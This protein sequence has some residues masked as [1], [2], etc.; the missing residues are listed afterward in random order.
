VV[1]L[2]ISELTG[3]VKEDLL[4]LPWRP[5]EAFGATVGV[6]SSGPRIVINADWWNFGAVPL[7]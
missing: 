4:A 7:S 3:A 5:A 2:A 1:T 6:P